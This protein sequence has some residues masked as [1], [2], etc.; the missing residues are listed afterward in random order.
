MA[1]RYWIGGGTNANWNS[2]PTTNWSATSGGVVRVAAPTSADDVTFDANGNS[3]STISA[4]ITVQSLTITSG[5]TSTMTHNAVLSVDTNWNFSSTYTIAG[6]SSVTWRGGFTGTITAGQTWPNSI[7]CTGGT[8]TFASDFVMSGTL[9]TSTSAVIFNET[10]AETFTCGGLTV[11]AQIT[12][13]ADIIINAGTWQGSSSNGIGNNL[14]INGSITISGIVYYRTGIITYDD[15]GGPYT[16]TATGSTLR[17]V[18]TSIVFDTDGM[19]WGAI[20]FSASTGLTYT[21]NSLLSASSIQIDTTT[22]T[23]DGT[24]GFTTGTLSVIR[25]ASTTINLKESITYTITTSFSC[26]QSRNGSSVLFT[27]PHASTRAN[28][29]MVNPSLCNVLAN[30]TR[31]SSTGGRTINT[32]NG[33][34]TDCENIRSFH[35][36]QTVSSAF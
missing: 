18:A 11:N 1:A 23:F 26:Y 20:E 10:T 33:T 17:N 31:I 35:D 6:T 32:F 28:L 19:T 15:T 3:A 34:V 9:T 16:V 7:T 12:G 13:T 22:T 14:T 29:V 36:L 30:F 25:T 8:R 2:S 4:T 27:S 24:A 21:L 5:Y